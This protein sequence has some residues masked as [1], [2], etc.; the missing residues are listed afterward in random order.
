VQEGDKEPWIAYFNLTEGAGGS[1][2]VFSEITFDPAGGAIEGKLTRAYM[3]GMAEADTVF[4]TPTRYGYTFLGWYGDEWNDPKKYDEDMPEELTLTAKWQYDAPEDNSGAGYV[5]IV[6]VETERPGIILSSGN[7]TTLPHSVFTLTKDNPYLNVTDVPEERIFT[8]SATNEALKAAVVDEAAG[9]YTTEANRVLRGMKAS[10]RRALGLDTFENEKLL[11][12]PVF[13]AVT[14]NPGDTVLISTKITFGAAFEG[15]KLGSLVPL[16]LKPDGNTV[17]L[18]WR[19]DPANISDGEYA[20]TN[21]EGK[22]YSENTV[23][24]KDSVMYLNV[25]IKDNGELDWDNETDKSVID[26]LIVAGAGSPSAAA[27]T[28]A[29]DGYEAGGGCNAGAGLAPIGLLL[30]AAALRRRGRR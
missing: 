24:L 10:E 16:K 7:M 28:S 25:G 6:Y 14:Q 19:R 26:P 21:K 20:W 18:N 15:T 17:M 30:V 9:V 13:K 11:Q 23:I 1:A 29:G 12:M 2:D 4:P 27:P 22:A 5:S 3:K 8:E